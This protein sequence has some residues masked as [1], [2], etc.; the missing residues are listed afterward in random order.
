[1]M[2]AVMPV[3]VVVAVVVA[4]TSL[5]DLLRVIRG[6]VGALADTTSRDHVRTYF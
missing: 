1:M 2:V 4:D 6:T 3:V 5:I